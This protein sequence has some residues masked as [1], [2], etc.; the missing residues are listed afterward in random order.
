MRPTLA[1]LA[2]DPADGPRDP[3]L[4]INVLGLPWTGNAIRWRG[5]CWVDI[6][7]PFSHGEGER[8]ISTFDGEHVRIYRVKEQ[9][10]KA[11]TFSR[12]Y[13]KIASPK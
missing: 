6:P 1:I 5:P 12:L 11:A 2:G 7:G 9:G 8:I 3:I 4:T 10:R 13:V